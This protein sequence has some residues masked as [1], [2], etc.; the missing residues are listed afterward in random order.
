M[1]SKESVEI[2]TKI[3]ELYSKTII[4]Q[5][6]INESENPLELK[7]YIYND[8]RLLFSSFSSKIGDSITVRSKVIKKEKGKEKYTD[9]IS[10]GNAAIF[11]TK[12]P[13]S[14]RMIVNL[15]N[16]PPKQEV[17]FISEFLQ[18]MESS[19]KFEFELFRNLPVLL[20]KGSTIQ[21]FDI[22]GIVE[23][24]TKDAIKIDKIILSENLNII[25][26]EY[27]DE[28]KNN[29]LIKYEYKNLPKLIVYKHLDYIPSNKIYFEIEN[30][31]P[32]LFYQKSSIKEDEINYMIKYKY[33]QKKLNNNLNL[34]PAL[35]IFL[36]DQSSSM[37]GEPLEVA[38]QALILF[39]Q[40]LPAG[41]YY[42]IIG[43]GT[44]YKLYDKSP[45]EYTQ[46]NIE[47]SIGSVKTLYGDLGGTD[48]YS[49]LNYIYH[50]Y[51]S[52][53]K[54]KLP[55]NIFLLTDG[56]IENK[57]D[58]LKLIEQHSNEFS[59]YSIGIGEYFDSDLIKNAG[60][61]G[62]GNY[63]F[64]PDIK[65]LKKVVATEIKNS[66]IP[67]YS[68][69][70]L[71]T[72]LE[73]KCL[74]KIK[75][76]PL[77]LKNNIYYNFLYINENNGDVI[78][79][80]KIKLEFKYKL[81]NEIKEISEKYELKGE[82]L[83][84]G[85]ELSKLIIKKYINDNKEIEKEKKIEL[86]LKYQILT[87]YTSLFAEI[88][89]SEKISE[90]MKKE[91]INNDTKKSYG[92]SESNIIL[93]NSTFDKNIK[94]TTLEKLENDN[95][96]KELERMS[97]IYGAACPINF[98]S[99]KIV[100]DDNSNEKSK[101]SFGF[102]SSIGNSIKGLFSN[103]NEFN[104]KNQE[105]VMKIIDTQ[106][107]VEGFWD[108][109]EYSEKIKEKYKRQ[110]KLLKELK[111]KNINDQV[112]ITILII[113]FIKKEHKELLDE[114]VMIIQKAELFITKSTNDNY[115]NII[116]EVGMK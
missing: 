67:F 41:S 100:L 11:V 26:E 42:Q 6:L 116:K 9:S 39:L 60:I 48:I 52:Y 102:F 58:T 79:N 47:E 53:D 8:N 80:S 70:E 27:I 29:Y 108:L 1:M 28:N 110:F 20:L 36:I 72:P 59:I 17:I 64:C 61:L 44:Y 109:N 13:N 16:I 74:Y 85:E 43:F 94:N 35:Y 3:N 69:L 114:L 30:N 88:K 33:I 66:S 38:V 22:K 92:L 62:K 77:I 18:F 49:P 101:K 86:S 31:S 83:P 12:D 65:K 5:K 50:Y 104:L 112:A 7:I 84:L 63:N 76:N 71:E 75:D 24:K 82:E 99:D 97:G 105:C 87:I 57:D 96:M 56:E 32:I 98:L 103:K 45:K 37:R 51:E 113:Y 4:T 111:D 34:Y 115:E 89:L 2:N 10:S 40:S 14:N 95:Q 25:K 106:N 91:I 46:K 78:D 55:I 81:Y 73:E 107:F 54:L 15:G 23:I 90:E 68:D 21:P 19:N 93:E